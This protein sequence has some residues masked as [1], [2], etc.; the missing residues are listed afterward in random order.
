MVITGGMIVG[1]AFSQAPQPAVPLSSN[2][3]A[4]ALLEEAQW[5]LD[6][7]DYNTAHRLILEALGTSP[8]D[9]QIKDRAKSL[10]ASLQVKIQEKEKADQVAKK[11]TDEKNLEK[12]KN[13]LT[14]QLAEARR[15]ADHGKNDKASEAAL[16]VLKETDDP[17]LIA[18]ANDLLA[19]NRP[20]IIGLFRALPERLFTL[21]GWA[22][23]ILLAILLVFLPLLLFRRARALYKRYSWAEAYRDWKK[24]KMN[25]SFIT[26]VRANRK[27]YRWWAFQGV[28][29]A[30]KTGV[31][32]AV[33]DSIKRIHEAVPVGY[34]DLLHMERMKFQPVLFGFADVHVDPLPA[35]ESLNVQIGAVSLGGIAKAM[36]GLRSW[37]DAK[38]TWIKGT[39]TATDESITL[40][41]TRRNAN[42]TSV[43]VTAVA[44]KKG[45]EELAE[46]A[47]YMMYYSLAKESSL[48]EAEAA[49]KLREGRKLLDR[50]VSEQDPKQL[51]AAFNV[52]RT[53]RIEKPD[54]NEV[55]LYEGIALD[56]LE[57]HDEALK[58]FHYLTVTLKDTASKDLIEKA[59]YNQAVSLF[60]T[61]DP[62]KLN[63][64][65]EILDG[66]MG[67]PATGDLGSNLTASKENFTSSPLK[68]LA[69]ATK[70]NVIA[71]KPIFWTHY[72][73]AP[74]DRTDV[75]FLTKKNEAG[76]T[77]KG[78]VGEVETIATFLSGILAGPKGDAWDDATKQEVRWAIQNAYGN[79]YL[80]SASSYFLPPHVDGANEPTT[81]LDYLKKAYKYFQECEMLLP[82]GVETLTNLA[83]VLLEL[84]RE[85]KSY[86]YDEVRAYLTRA[87]AANPH[88]EYADYRLAE[89]WEQEGRIDEVVNVLRDFAKDRTPTI[90]SFKKLYSKYS[91][92]LA[93]FPVTSPVADAPNTSVTQPITPAG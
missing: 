90:S 29:D 36:T 75:M 82:P 53:V 61:Y 62:I 56:L 24:T 50:Y 52:F 28:E 91:L 19:H 92:Q 3:K 37:L 38:L 16:S 51:D 32:E 70:A 39:V 74:R 89:S 79:V 46:A 68:T 58:R 6:A 86:K 85:D 9:Q 47:T 93:K 13:K 48:S 42:G 23:D 43:T 88:Y 15:L 73:N 41:L 78:W 65:I 34:A 21:G 66:L 27:K 44:D 7:E 55:Y 63:S 40:R 33:I 83:T 17:K 54:F 67:L 64:A 4:T 49:N 72:C 87:K 71:H 11:T 77:I 84:S 10:W 1:S 30:T 60:R 12:T 80:N 31:A 81:R 5:H 59:T 45:I 35:L 76:E 22:L 8:G 69:L 26:Y 20:S 2:A 57:Q 14:A 25:N 18:E